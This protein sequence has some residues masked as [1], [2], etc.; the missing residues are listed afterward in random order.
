M[1]LYYPGLDALPTLHEDIIDT[2]TPHLETERLKRDLA[3]MLA[4][5]AT[6]ARSIHSQPPRRTAILSDETTAGAIKL[7]S[8]W[9]QRA[10]QQQLATL[11]LEKFEAD[12]ARRRMRE[13]RLVEDTLQLL[14]RLAL[15]THLTNEAYLAKCRKNH[16]NR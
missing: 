10:A 16:Q 4:M 12:E 13:Q 15:Q 2:D 11:M 14:D 3:A 8:W 1:D 5:D 7:Q 9:R 6:A